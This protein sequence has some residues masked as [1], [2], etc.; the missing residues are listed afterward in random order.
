MTVAVLITGSLSRPPALKTSK[1]GKPYVVATLKV[2]ADNAIDFWT[3]LAFSE[4]AQAELMRLDE[5]DKIAAQGSLKVETYVGKDGST[6]ISRTVLADHVLA[7]K[8]KPRAPKSA[9]AAVETPTSIAPAAPPAPS[10][11]RPNG[12]APSYFD[13][14]EPG[15]LYGK[16]PGELDDEIPF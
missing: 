13:N 5:G 2:A 9:K 16:K 10:A 12:P 6:K 3:V 8:P 14:A 11:R 7:L 1:A 4:S 15:D